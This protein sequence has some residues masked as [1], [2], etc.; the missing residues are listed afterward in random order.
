MR[1]LRGVVGQLLPRLDDASPTAVLA[2]LTRFLVEEAEAVS[3]RLWL[4]DY[5]EAVLVGLGGWGGTDPAELR[6]VGDPGPG[7]AFTTERTVVTTDAEGVTVH[8]PVS[9]RAER[10]GVLS[11]GVGHSAQPE[12]MEELQVDPELEGVARTVAYVLATAMRYTDAFERAR[13][14]QPLSLAAEMQWSMVAA[15]SFSAPQFR[16]AGQVRPAY[17]IGGDA[18]DVCV[19]P[20]TLWLVVIDAMGHG[21]QAAVLTTLALTA[22]RNARRSGLSL[23]TQVEAADQALNQ[24]FGGA[25]FVTGLL[26]QVD[27]ATG[28]LEMINAGHPPPYLVRAGRVEGI[29][30]SPHLPIGLFE[31]V[32]YTSTPFQLRVSDRWVF[33]SDGVTEAVVDENSRFGDVLLSQALADCAGAPTHQ[34]VDHLHGALGQIVDDDL[35]DDASVIVVDWLGPG[36]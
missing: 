4:A 32:S 31:E 26:L 28:Q 22:L 2:V 24:T 30:T 20:T 17:H 8:L 34:A 13:R 16:L 11:V 23:V 9:I 12:G 7:Q 19:G 35:H 6:E 29:E 14:L 18:Y 36:M 27:L 25:Q 10:L 15:R 1:S 33:V 5:D 3:V 21:T